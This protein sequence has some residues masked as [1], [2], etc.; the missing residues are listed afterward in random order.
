MV[1]QTARGAVDEAPQQRAARPAIDAI[2]P[3]QRKGG[4]KCA[5][6]R[7]PAENA[8]ERRAHRAGPEPVIE[9]A[10]DDRRRCVVRGSNIA[11]AD[12]TAGDTTLK[13][14]SLYFS[15]E[16]TTASP[17]YVDA[18]PSARRAKAICHANAHID[19]MTA[20][21]AAIQ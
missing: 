4:G 3:Q 5:E 11:Y 2:E 20:T 21:K 13:T 9:I 1:G 18:P 14:R 16:I 19:A 17:P 10:D 7:I 6:P 8:A 12:P 15:A